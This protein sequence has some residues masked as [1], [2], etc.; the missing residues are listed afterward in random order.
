M[1]SRD[2]QVD[3]NAKTVG[4]IL[5]F[6]VS[7]VSHLNQLM[8]TGNVKGELFEIACIHIICFVFRLKYCDD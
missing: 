7:W 5:T 2:F 4:I 1:F 8:L 3:L 6:H